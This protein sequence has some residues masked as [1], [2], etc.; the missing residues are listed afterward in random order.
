[1]DSISL[2]IKRSINKFSQTDHSI[3]SPTADIILLEYG[4]YECPAAA[5]A[6]LLTKHLIDVFGDEMRLI[7]RHFPLTEI[8]PHA[9]L[10]AEA[11]EAAGAQGQFW[12]MHDLLFTHQEHLKMASL[13]NYAEQ[14]ELDMIRFAAEMKER[15]YLQRIKEERQSGEALNIRTSPSFFLNGTPIDVTFGL[16]NL[17]NSV[18][19]L[20][21]QSDW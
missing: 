2:Q 13:M 11:A 4:D 7:Y 9:E 16:E 5:S 20:M 1:M 15:I 18:I 21:Q 17:E 8:H 12:G 10:A 3:G 14:L 6:E 19:A